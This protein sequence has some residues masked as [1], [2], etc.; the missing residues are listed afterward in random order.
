[1]VQSLGWLQVA[2][3]TQ[4]NIFNSTDNVLA[5]IRHGGITSSERSSFKRTV[6]GMKNEDPTTA[7]LVGLNSV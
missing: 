2:K 5:G 6:G 7:V 4:G 1:M 3:S